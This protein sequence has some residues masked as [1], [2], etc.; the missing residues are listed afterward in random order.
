MDKI[1]KI[2]MFKMLPSK[3]TEQTLLGSVSRLG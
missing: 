2:D 1:K 3:M